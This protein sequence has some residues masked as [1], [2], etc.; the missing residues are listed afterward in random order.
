MDINSLLTLKQAW[1]T[2]CR[3]HPRFPGFIDA[4]KQRGL[5]EGTELTVTVTYPDGQNL[6]AGLKLKDTDAELI[7]T[8][9]PMK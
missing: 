6:K 9:I 3:N 2:F 1:N 7:R 8:F 4:V 5:P